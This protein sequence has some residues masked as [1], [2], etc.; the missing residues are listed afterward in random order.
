VAVSKVVPVALIMSG[1][2]VRSSDRSGEGKNG[3]WAVR[4][5]EIEQMSGA[6]S[7]IEVWAERGKF[8]NDAPNPMVGDY[9]ACNVYVR[10]TGNEP[11]LRFH[12][13]PF[14]EL[15]RIHSALSNKKAA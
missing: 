1:K 6:R 10:E 13:W 7:D 5:I 9:F 12:S 3:P 8:S 2:V 14:D 11:G 4:T 15:D